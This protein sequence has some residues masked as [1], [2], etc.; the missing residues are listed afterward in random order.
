MVFVMFFISA[1]TAP[2]LSPGKFLSGVLLGSAIAFAATPAH[3]ASGGRGPGANTSAVPAPELVGESWLN[4]AADARPSLAAR[5]GKVTVVHFWTFGCIN[6]KR[7][8]PFYT[9]WQKRF[10]GRGLEIIGIHTPE[11]AEEKD[12][13]NVGKKVKEYGITYPVLFDRESENWKRWQQRYWPAVYLV[14][15]QGRARFVWEGELEYQNAGGNLKMIGLIES[16]LRE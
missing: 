15:K 7:N 13:A 12:M 11:T 16:L 4:V 3:A 2:L 8:L 10:S 14:D 9:E 5:K 6:C 1:L